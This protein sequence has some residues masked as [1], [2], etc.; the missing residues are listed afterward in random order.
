MID[1]ADYRSK[2]LDEGVAII[3]ENLLNLEKSLTR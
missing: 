1:N 2:Q 3:Y